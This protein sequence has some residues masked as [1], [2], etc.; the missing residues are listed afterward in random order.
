VPD[1]LITPTPPRRQQRPPRRRRPQAP[2]AAAPSPRLGGRARAQV[3]RRPDWAPETVW[4]AEK[5]TFKPDALKAEFEAKNELAA[6][7]AAEES[8]KL[9]FRR[10]PRNTSSRCRRTSSRPEGV[11]FKLDEADPLFT[12]AR[13]WAHK[14]GISQEA[15]EQGL[16]MIAARDVA[17]RR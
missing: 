14:N 17:S 8:K 7:K 3:R 6:F 1:D 11:E 13:D 15:F 12:Q 2:V 4:D 16:S 5:N 10:S 9:P